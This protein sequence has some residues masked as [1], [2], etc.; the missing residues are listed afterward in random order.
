MDEKKS[1]SQII[2][3][4]EI[5][6][7]QNKVLFYINTKIFPSSVVQKAAAKF[8]ENTWVAIDGDSDELLVELKPKQGMDL[9]L[10]GREFNNAL[11]EESTHDLTVD[12][13]NDSLVSRIKKVVNE[14]VEEQEGK[15]SKQSIIAISALLAGIGLASYSTQNVAAS[16]LCACS[17]CCFKPDQLVLTPHGLT[18]IQNIKV[19]ST[20]I[21][22]DETTGEK[23]V[24]KV[25]KVLIHDGKNENL[26]SY[27]SAPLINLK[28]E[29]QGK[30]IE[31]KVTENHLY[32]DPKRGDYKRLR[33]FNCG[34]K[35][36]TAD[37]EGIVV[38]KEAIID[39]TSPL[40]LHSQ[41][42]YDLEMESSPH[43]YFVNNAV[44][45]NG[46]CGDGSCDG[47]DGGDGGDGGDGAEREGSEGEGS[48]G[49]GSDGGCFTD[50]CG[51]ATSGIANF[52]MSET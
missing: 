25:R 22:Y 34:E 36:K 44:V 15:I 45:H 48:E 18:E 23:V 16:H 13:K 10:L 33:H 7:S 6:N 49:C 38:S 1:P 4:F 50:G 9:E 47:C 52:Y 5:N 42:V 20:V 39:S 17:G 30:I 26:G 43:N 29:S 11:L 41:I 31:T 46:G 51:E 12:L 32:F 28:V 35:I 21:S 19:G 2:S 27:A 37:G 8:R 3:N 14:F 24:S 40:A